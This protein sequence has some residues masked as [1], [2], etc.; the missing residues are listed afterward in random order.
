MYLFFPLVQKQIWHKVHW[1]CK[2]VTV[3][4][5]EDHELFTVHRSSDLQQDEATDRVFML[6]YSF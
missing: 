3:N 6:S 4:L 1:S 5:L 2:T